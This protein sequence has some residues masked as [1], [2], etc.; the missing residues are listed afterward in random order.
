M[1]PKAK[2]SPKLDIARLHVERG[3]VAQ[4]DTKT[5]QLIRVTAA[6]QDIVNGCIDLT[7]ENIAVT[8]AVVG[9]AFATAQLILGKAE[10]WLASWEP[11]HHLIAGRIEAL[12]QLASEGKASRLTGN[13]AYTLFASNLVDYA[14]KYRGM[15][16][17]TLSDYEAY[18]DV[19]LTTQE[20][21]KWT[22]P[23]YFIDS[24]AHLAGFVVGLFKW[25]N[26]AT[27]QFA[28]HR[29]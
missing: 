16:R 25:R 6:T 22:V 13:M 5:P 7:W 4:S 23:P 21:G 24:V 29:R 1:M 20:S 11:L 28:N 8:G 9:D 15:Q 12:D 26:G 2:G 27:D 19:Q 3:L 17:V 14:E 10:D 18:A